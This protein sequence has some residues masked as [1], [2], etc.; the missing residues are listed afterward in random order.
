[1]DK[2]TRIITLTGR[3]GVGKT[4]VAIAAAKLLQREGL[5]VDGFYSREIRERGVRRGFEIVDFVTGERVVL[6]DIGIDGPRIGKYRVNMKG[7]EGFVPRIVDRAKG[8]QVILCDEI[9]P[10]EL[11][12]PNFKRSMSTLLSM[13]DKKLIAVV[14]RSMKDPV[15]KA[16]ARHP[17]GLLIEVTEDNRD[18][19]P[20]EI[21]KILS[22]SGKGIV[23]C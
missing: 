7:V 16:F 22:G 2:G 14:H 3:P 13:R 21:V 8:A 17:E 1:M 19:L 11:L 23:D 18:V 15:M 20:V 10:M 6:A 4:T 12:S 5:L 9:G